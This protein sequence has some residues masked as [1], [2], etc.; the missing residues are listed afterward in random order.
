L[1]LCGSRGLLR[2]I[3]SLPKEEFSRGPN[4]K[5]HGDAANDHTSREKTRV[6]HARCR[7]RR[8]RRRG[9]H[10]RRPVADDPGCPLLI[11]FCQVRG[12]RCT[13][14]SCVDSLHLG[15]RTVHEQHLVAAQ[16]DGTKMLNSY[17][18]PLLCFD[19]G[20]ADTHIL[21]GRMLAR[22]LPKKRRPT[23][24]SALITGSAGATASQPRPNS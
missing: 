4:S 8:G 1:V 19:F 24:V 3:L 14:A 10:W 5:D 2:P 7:V 20:T 11:K 12:E 23:E 22:E 16:P 13:A 17:F 15:A 21:A 6:C 18:W 9:V